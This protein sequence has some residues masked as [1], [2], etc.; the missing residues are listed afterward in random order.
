MRKPHDDT[1]SVVATQESWMI[2][3]SRV[4]HVVHHRQ[5][6]LRIGLIHNKLDKTTTEAS[7]RNRVYMGRNRLIDI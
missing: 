3:F 5:R 4:G 7:K 1:A 2:G 6:I